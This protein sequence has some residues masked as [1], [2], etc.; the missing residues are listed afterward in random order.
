[1]KSFPFVVISFFAL[2]LKGLVAAFFLNVP[3]YANYSI[4]LLWS[5]MSLL[6]GSAGGLTSLQ[7]K[8]A[9]YLKNTSDIIENYSKIISLIAVNFCLIAISILLFSTL[10]SE[11]LFPMALGVL[12]G[13]LNLLFAVLTTKTK[14]RLD[15]S[16]YALFLTMKAI[17]V[18]GAIGLAGSIY[19]KFEILIIAEAM[20]LL[21]LLGYIYWDEFFTRGT[22]LHVKI[23][24]QSEYRKHL[25]L[26]LYVL[27]AALFLNID[28]MIG[29]EKLQP[30]EIA[31]FGIIA[32]GVG[33]GSMLH[34]TI[35]SFLFPKLTV[36]LVESGERVVIVKSI[37][38]SLVF[39]CAWSYWVSL[40]IYSISW[41][42][43][44]RCD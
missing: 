40:N 2:G 5:Q 33:A 42:Q 29:F 44:T 37:K 38:Y 31:T 11:R 27:G 1:M 23:R 9:T 28:R 13:T 32:I 34:A 36:D 10:E 43:S 15:F 24:V 21:L 3:E 18:L 35:N 6:L 39:F 20:S 16:R 7:V 12:L 30:I 25:K 41:I 19:P 8:T 26:F 4:A 17:G 14:T 22:R